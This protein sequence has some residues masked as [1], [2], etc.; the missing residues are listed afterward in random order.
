M[1]VLK[2]TE[3]AH[4]L[5]GTA[6][7]RADGEH[8]TCART[9]RA[10][11]ELLLDRQN[12]EQP[13]SWAIAG[14]FDGNRRSRARWL[15]ACAVVLD[16]DFEDPTVPKD[17]GAHQEIPPTDRS[18]I[19]TALDDY[20]LP[21][22]AY[23]TLRGLRVGHLLSK[24]ITDEDLYAEIAE[25]AAGKLLEHLESHGITTWR[26][27][28]TGLRYDSTSGRPSQPMLLPLPG[29]PYALCGE[30]RS[31]GVSELREDG[32]PR[33]DLDAALPSDV[34]EACRQI[35]GWV[36]IAP[37]VVVTNLMALA[38]GA[39]GNTRWVQA[40]GF[41]VPLSLQYLSVHPSGS[42]KSEVRRYMR[43]AV[44]EIE[45]DVLAQRERA[46]LEQKEYAQRLDDWRTARR[47]KNGSAIAG[48]RPLP[49]P[50]SP[51]G[52]ERASYIVSEA[53][54]EG[55][56]A[57]LEDTPRGVLWA[58]DEA[59]EVVGLL[60]RYGGSGGA[61]SLDAARLR[62]L[63]ES[64]PVEAHRA[65]SNSSPVRRLP[66]PWLAIDADVQPGL[67][68]GLFSDED[69]ASGLTARW[70]PHAPPSMQGR[71]R[72]VKPPAE[73][74]PWVLDTLRER[75]GSLWR[76]ELELR[77][78]VPWYEP[79]RLD[80]GAERIWAEELERLERRYQGAGDEE[81]GALGHARGRLLRV[82]GVV[83]HL[84]DAQLRTATEEDMRRAIVQM[85]YHLA[86]G[87]ALLGGVEA[88]VAANRLKR[89]DE[90]CRR[91]LE[92]TPERGVNPRELARRV[93]RRRYTGE[94][95]FRRA[96]ADLNALG[97]IVRRPPSTGRGRRPQVAWYP[98][99]VSAKPAKPERE[100]PGEDSA[101]SA[102]EGLETGTHNDRSAREFL[103]RAS[104]ILVNT[105]QVEFPPPGRRVGCPICKSSDGFGVLPDDPSR[106]YCHSDRH[107]AGGCAV[108]LMLGEKLDRN[109]TP[110]E[111]V[112]EARRILGVP[113]EAGEAAL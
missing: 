82:A 96:V 22:F 91:I 106:W 80:A 94:G 87:R 31:V 8:A 104:E 97:W 41:A 81:A 17:E 70:L 90:R 63:T 44:E 108:D 3:P 42:G 92:R 75:L 88:S 2:N 38:S 47:R 71:R 58:T 107:K 99:G 105:G 109:P 29:Q 37:E 79:V 64:Q 53:T 84:R 16:L 27:G 69:R 48:P 11:L 32:L 4:L 40:R 68:D 24:D 54:L 30:D 85:R 14:R 36:Q 21:A 86:H 28:E 101:D 55:I 12:K 67:I 35:G 5:I 6:L 34:A 50:M 7:T 66:R 103:E 110:A 93:S 59:H 102:D 46:L 112:E 60:G 51:R 72:Y 76:L 61:R 89:L 23:T 20:E 57:T 62:R 95:G 45:R 100:G 113:K 78:G 49:P 65:R 1:S 52:G 39:I 25:A 26:G 33:L 19:L 15:G 18:R 77:D 10:V 56:V 13:G 83:G 73:P 98:P 111:A 74:E 43:K 9:P